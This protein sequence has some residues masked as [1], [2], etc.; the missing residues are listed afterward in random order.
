MMRKKRQFLPRQ[1]LEA[2]GNR[3]DWAAAA[4]FVLLAYRAIYPII[5]AG[6]E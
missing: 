1:V 4:V 6:D 2:G 3:W 5:P